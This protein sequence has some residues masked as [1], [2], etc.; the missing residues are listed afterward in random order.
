MGIIY[1]PLHLAYGINVDGLAA[2]VQLYDLNESTYAPDYSV[3]PLVLRPWLSITDPDGY[4]SDGPVEIA[5]P[6]WYIVE[7]ETVTGTDSG[8]N[9]TTT[10]Q[11]KKTEVTSDGTRFEI[12]APGSIDAGVLKL[13]QNLTAG[14][15]LN[16]LFCG[17]FADERL[18]QLRKIEIPYC[19]RCENVAQKPI[20]SLDMP[21]LMFWNYI[22]DTDPVITI[23]PSLRIGTT[24]VP[25]AHREYV[26][27]VWR[28]SQ[29]IWSEVDDTTTYADADLDY[30]IEVAAD[31]TS[32]T[33]DRSLIQDELFLRV[34]AKYDPFGN[35][36]GVTLNAD[37]PKAEVKIIRRLPRIKPTAVIQTPQRFREDQSDVNPT[38]RVF[39]GNREVLNPEQYFKIN[40]YTAQGVSGGNIVYNPTSVAEGVSPVISLSHVKKTYGGKIRVGLEVLD[41]P[42]AWVDSDNSRF[43]DTDG[44]M[45]LI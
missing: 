42:K 44:K 21:R 41:P 27:E 5:N 2:D 39:V 15:T 24:A 38:V 3:V 43:I 4:Y 36:S 6:K 8:G 1:S 37:A 40:W 22:F 25:A 33:V 16:L 19:V 29:N 13:K 35:P 26:W 20:L 9:P 34:R 11:E 45:L 12:T 30:E 28:P 23:T 32:A 31:K 10:K 14:S 18:G 17:E 7:E